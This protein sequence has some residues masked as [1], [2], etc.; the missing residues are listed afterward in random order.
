MIVSGT[1]FSAHQQLIN[2]VMNDDQA[3]C[4]R[5]SESSKDHQ[6]TLLFRPITSRVASDVAAAMTEI[7][8][9][10]NGDAGIWWGVVWLRFNIF[11]CLPVFWYRR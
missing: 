6:V 9:E 1:T 5:F 11:P 8:G 4:Y 2:E 7:H 3:R 10:G